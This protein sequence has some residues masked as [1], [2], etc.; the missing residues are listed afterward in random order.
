[1]RTPSASFRGD[2]AHA[3]GRSFRRGASSG[4]TFAWP[5]STGTTIAAVHSSAT[6][7]V[8]LPF[9][10]SVDQRASAAIPSS[11]F[12]YSGQVRVPPARRSWLGRGLDDSEAAPDMLVADRLNHRGLLEAHRDLRLLGIQFKLGNRLCNQEVDLLRCALNEGSPHRAEERIR[13]AAERVS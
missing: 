8:M 3:M 7:S 13:C 1:M 11:Y 4:P 5:Q 9:A 10:Q 2:S 12:S 6:S